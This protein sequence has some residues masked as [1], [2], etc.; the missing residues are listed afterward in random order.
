M[1]DKDSFVGFEVDY[2]RINNLEKTLFETFQLTKTNMTVIANYPNFSHSIDLMEYMQ[3]TAGEPLWKASWYE[4]RNKVAPRLRDS[5]IEYRDLKNK[6]ARISGHKSLAHLWV[7]TLEIELDV[8]E[9][10]VFK[11]AQDFKPFYKKMHA[12]LRFKLKEKYPDLVDEKGLIPVHLTKNMHGQE[13]NYWLDMLQPYGEGNNVNF[14]PVLREMFGENTTKLAEM[15]DKFFQSIGFPAVPA[16]F[17]EKSKFKL[18]DWPEGEQPKCPPK[19]WNAY[20][21][22]DDVRIEMCGVPPSMSSFTTIHH[23]MGH[24]HN[25]LLY[26]NQ[27]HIYYE[28]GSPAFKEAVGDTIGILAQSLE[29]LLSVKLLEEP[30]NR[31]MITINRLMSTALINFPRIPYIYVVDRWMLDFFLERTNDN[32]LNTY[33]WY[34]INKHQGF[35]PP[36]GETRGEEYFDMM[37]K[38]HVAYIQPIVA[39]YLIGIAHQFQFLEAICKDSGETFEYLADCYI[40]NKPN[41]TWKFREMMRKGKSVYWRK[42][43]K[44]F[45][46]DDFPNTRA[47]LDYYKPLEEWL[48][49]FIKDNNVHVGWPGDE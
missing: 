15:A 14:N 18:S 45:T 44:D 39:S 35:S 5:M 13:W 2:V 7:E 26:S 47:I 22:R 4:Y 9:N 1:A 49:Q 46:G 11:I 6:W 36:N 23:E 19:T 34:L 17:F 29:H 33:W 40:D 25:Y 20:V 21:P 38:M 43:L 31:S 27:T 28:G 32:E 16:I 10:M 48:D 24:V 41:A 8:Y 3:K 37:A 30:T 42:L 12:Y